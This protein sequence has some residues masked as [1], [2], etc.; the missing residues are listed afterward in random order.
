MECAR[1][2]FRLAVAVCA[3]WAISHTQIAEAGTTLSN[4]YWSR[5]TFD[6]EITSLHMNAGLVS[7]GAQKWT[8]YASYLNR[9]NGVNWSREQIR[10]M[11]GSFLGQYASL[12]NVGGFP[13]VSCY[14]AASADYPTEALRYGHWTASGFW[15]Y[16]DVG[17]GVSF[18]GSKLQTMLD[19]RPVIAYSA[20]DYSLRFA[21]PAGAGTSSSEPWY[22]IGVGNAS[23]WYLS[24]GI[25]PY[26]RPAIGYYDPVTDSLK[27]AWNALQYPTFGGWNFATIDNVGSPGKEGALSIAVSANGT[28]GVAYT[29]MSSQPGPS[30]REYVYAWN[31]GGAWERTVF[32]ENWS[33]VSYGPPSASL[34][35]LDDGTPVIAY[36]LDGVGGGLNVAWQEDGTWK[37][38]QVEDYS[39]EGWYPSIAILQDTRNPATIY[40]DDYAS[41]RGMRYAE[42][43]P[44]PASLGALALGGLALIRRRKK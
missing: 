41:D 8:A 28:V 23:S 13:V 42:F 20:S 7:C 32:D 33:D 15:W 4:G 19:G 11:D 27:Y 17:G 9:Y 36:F 25:L 44:E 24:L 34:T 43:I 14:Q 35:F 38:T 16:R 12:G 3:G 40:W 6:P 39:Y 10:F 26:N 2:G 18:G 30:K 1:Y 21:Y 22:N 29:R 31:S 5:T 37:N